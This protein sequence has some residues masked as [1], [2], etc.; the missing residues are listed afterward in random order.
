MSFDTS[1]AYFEGEVHGVGSFSMP[2]LSRV[3]RVVGECFPEIVDETMICLRSP[4]RCCSRISRTRSALNLE[5]V[6]SSQ[7]TTLIDFFGGAERQVLPLGQVHAQVVRLAL[8]VDLP[9]EARRGRSPAPDPAQG[10]PRPGAGAARSG[11]ET[12]TCSK[13]S[14]S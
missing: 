1:E 4:R 10:L 12:R 3:Y 14:R 2:S 11:S 9:R 7:K 6:P 13:T 8:G 5:G